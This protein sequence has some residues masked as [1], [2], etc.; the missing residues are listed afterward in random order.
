MFVVVAG[1]DQ[2][3]AR[4]AEALMV[5]HSVVVVGSEA[6]LG[7]STERL[8]VEVVFGAITSPR[9]MEEA[10]V[11]EADA[12]VACTTNDEQ[13]I[14]ACLAA[15][16]R[17][18]ARTVCLLNGAGFLEDE[19]ER[20][21]SEALGIDVVI[22]PGQQ[23]ATEIVRIVTV[24]GAL[25]VEVFADGSMAL[26]RVAVEHGAA[27]CAAPLKNLKLPKQ[28]LIV[29]VRREE[30][31][32]LPKGGTRIEPGD[33]LILM[34]RWAPLQELLAAARS[35]DHP[36]LRLR[37]AVIGAGTVGV[38][39]ARGLAAAKWRVKLIESDLARCEVVAD[40]LDSLVLHGDGADLTLL[41]EERIGEMP[42]VVAVTNNDEKNL[43]ISLLSKQLGVE[44]IVTRADKLSNELMFEKVGIDV[45]RSSRGAAVR[46]V[47]RSIV[48][49]EFEIRAVLEHGDASVIEVTLPH[50]FEPRLVRDV[51]LP[52]AAVIGAI[53]RG[54]QGLVPGGNDK[55]KSYDRLLIFCHHGEEEETRAYFLAHAHSSKSERMR[56]A[57]VGESSD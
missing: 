5:D 13:N 2:M 51:N 57:G 25:E 3:A 9:V 53:L 52:T 50:N 28:A 18:G 12:F 27:L 21:V 29:A 19:E 46:S 55:L 34:G 6:G 56:A 40:E 7:S 1:D 30:E 33:R 11:G 4:I 17:G 37:A 32:I 45:V 54:S 20:D 35:K 36:K 8:D 31:L 41:E 44:R 16:R 39:V 42:V 24:P 26:L 23:L 48:K 10:R 14:V 22:R 47:V 38:A 15:K 49:T 43:L